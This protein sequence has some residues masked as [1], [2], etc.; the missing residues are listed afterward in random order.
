MAPRTMGVV[1]APCVSAVAMLLI[2]LVLRLAAA[3]PAQAP[4]WD[5]Q[6]SGEEWRRAGTCAAPGCH[7]LPWGRHGRLRGLRR[8]GQTRPSRRGGCPAP[9]LLQRRGERGFDLPLRGV[10]DRAEG[11][12]VLLMPAQ[13]NPG[14]A[15]D[16][17]TTA[18]G[19]PGVAPG[20]AGRGA[21]GGAEWRLYAGLGGHGALRR[22]ARRGAP[23]GGGRVPATTA[24]LS[25][26][27]PD[28][29]HHHD[30]E[31]DHPRPVLRDPFQGLMQ[32]HPCCLGGWAVGGKLHRNQAP[33]SRLRAIG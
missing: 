18:A 22:E 25:P 6:R 8:S 33:I 12:P 21:H 14:P 2:I 20:A 1:A 29:D 16:A 27:D 4:R 26:A 15:L 17:L 32:R 10:R 5:V 3:T 30:H 24:G 23:R 7:A 11:R 19:A 13:V 31:D 9:G 28:R